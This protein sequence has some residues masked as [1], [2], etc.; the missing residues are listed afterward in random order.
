MFVPHSCKACWQGKNY[1]FSK[2][3]EHCWLVP[4]CVPIMIPVMGWISQQHNPKIYVTT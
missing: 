4:N 2:V 3:Y 1:D